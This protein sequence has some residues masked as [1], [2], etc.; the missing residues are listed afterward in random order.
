MPFAE[1][2]SVFFD[3]K[4]FATDALLDGVGVSGIFRNGYVDAEGISTTGPAY[5]LESAAAE[6][7]EPDRSKLVVG[8]LVDGTIYDVVDVRPSGAGTTVLV[9]RKAA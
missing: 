1:D 8:G 7:T 9:L 2:M 6:C 4:E 3:S 5:K